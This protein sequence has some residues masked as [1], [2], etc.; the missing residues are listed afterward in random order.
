M[1]R[2]D[3]DISHVDYQWKLIVI[4][5]SHEEVQKLGSFQFNLNTMS[6]GSFLFNAVEKK[7]LR[8]V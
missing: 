7:K 8:N 4:C 5:L 3:T 2:F 6:V 1:T